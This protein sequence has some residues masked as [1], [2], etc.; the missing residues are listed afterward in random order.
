MKLS[1]DLMAKRT[2]DVVLADPCFWES[3]D[4][5]IERASDDE[6]A[7]ELNSDDSVSESAS[8]DCDL[9]G[10][11]RDVDVAIDLE[12]DDSDEYD[13]DGEAPNENAVPVKNCEWTKKLTELP[14]VSFV[15]EHLVGVNKDIEGVEH[16]EAVNLFQLLFT[17]Y[18]LRDIVVETNR[19]AKQC[20][21]GR[22]IQKD[23]TN[24]SVPELKTWLGLVIAT[25]IVQK[26]GRI[27]SYWSKHWLTQT[28]GFNQTM[29]SKRFLQILSCI[30]FV[31]N[32]ST[33]VNKS[34]KFWKIRTLLDYV[35]K[36]FQLVYNPEREIAVDETMLKFKGRLGI[37][38]Y[39][40]NKPIKWGIKL[41]TLAESSSGYVLNIIPYAGKREDTQLSKTAQIVVDVCQ[42]FLNKGH[43]LFMD[44]YYTSIELIEYLSQV[45]TLSCGTVNSNRKRLPSDMKNSATKKLKKGESLKRIS[46]NVLAVSW[47]DT[48]VVN[49]LTNIPGNLDDVDIQR[50][51]KKQGGK[52]VTIS[53]PRAIITYNS[54]MGGVDLSDQRVATYRRHMKSLTWYIVKTLCCSSLYCT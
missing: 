53:K 29:T 48:R 50:R 4:S 51:D 10:L 45:K 40:K 31:D 13:D 5:D 7:F 21:E 9:D 37:K 44:N 14:D 26:K 34:D 47:K 16:F 15:F 43:Y 54:Y 49:L 18:I 28:P 20:Q 36:R 38:Q 3:D 42:P 23:W 41:F 52:E 17:D 8:S 22:H 1:T 32:S 33:T 30:H 2:V 39:I 24:I 46:N 25:G 11:A 35:V 19:Y 27:A 12:H 6:S